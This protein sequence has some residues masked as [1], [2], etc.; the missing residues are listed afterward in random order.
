MLGEGPT[1]AASAAG[2]GA[3][4]AGDGEAATA[5]GEVAGLAAGEG[6]TVAAAPWVRSMVPPGIALLGCRSI[7]YPRW[8]S[9][10]RACC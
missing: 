10:R 8:C 2:D 3:D 5:A 9:H 7:S 4:T 6:A 1:A